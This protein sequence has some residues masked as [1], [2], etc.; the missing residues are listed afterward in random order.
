MEA[1]KYIYIV[2]VIALIV[3]FVLL[4]KQLVKLMKKAAGL[5]DNID[6]LNNNISRV[7]DKVEDIKQTKESWQFFAT[8]YIVYSILKETMKD[9]KSSSILTRGIAKSFTKTCAKNVSKLS[10][11]KI[12]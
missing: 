7:N 3:V 2:I 11:I 12:K 1:M 4:I 10:K 9:Y 5:N 8:V 6:K